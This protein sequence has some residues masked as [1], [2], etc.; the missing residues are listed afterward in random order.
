MIASP[1]LQ[2]YRWQTYQCVYE[3][4]P[5]P[6]EVDRAPL[7]LV[8]P[9]GVGLSR[10]FWGRFCQAWFEQGGTAAIYN[11]DLLGCGD[12]DLPHVAFYP[13]DWADQLG[14]FFE[15]IVK[16]PAVLVVQG[17]LMPVAVEFAVKYPQWVEA[18]VWSGPPAWPLISETKETWPQQAS[19]NL[20]DSPLGW[21]FY[22]YARTEAFLRDFSIKQLFARPKAVDQEWLDLLAQGCQ[23]LETRHAVYSFL[24]GFWRKDYRPLLAQ[25]QAPV[26]IVMGE[27]ASSISRDAQTYCPTDRLKPY[28]ETLPQAQGIEIPGRNVLPYESTAAFTD[29]VRNFLTHT[30]FL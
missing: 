20:F 7:V 1:P 12:G 6:A 24:S 23:S 17:A 2:A 11:P 27:Q 9:I 26:L 29:A 30:N 10:R 22:L 14:Q 3:H 19:W 4:Y 25:I 5:A 15:V 18:M 28:L 16:R 8:H 13:E 21:G